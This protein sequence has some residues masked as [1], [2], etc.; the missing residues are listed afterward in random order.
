VHV[1]I[2]T[3]VGCRGRAAKADL[4]RL[5][6]R[7]GVLIDERQIAPGRGAYLHRSVDCLELAV[8]RRSVGRALRVPAIDPVALTDGVTPH[9]GGGPTV[10]GNRL[11]IIG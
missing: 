8:R 2:R 10:A 3:C 9:L 1:P 4:L 7:D 5:A 6:W 11:R